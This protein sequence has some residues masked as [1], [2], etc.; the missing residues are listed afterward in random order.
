MPDATSL[1]RIGRIMKAV[2][3][4]ATF[5]CAFT[6]LLLAL[7]GVAQATTAGTVTPN[8]LAF[9][10]V[11]VNA[12]SNQMLTFTNTGDVNETVSSS[13]DVAAFGDAGGCNGAVLTPNATCQ[14]QVSFSPTTTGTSTGTLTV[15]FTSQVDS[16]TA[17]V[18]VPLS[19]TAVYPA[20][21][22]QSTSL[23]PSY[24]YPL[25]RDGYRD[26]ADYAFTLNENATGAIQIYN[27]KGTL[28]RSY[29]FT[30]RDHLA[31]AWGGR[32]SLGEKVK[33]GFYRFRVVAHLPGLSVVSAF[34]RTQVKTGFRLETTRGTKSKLG[35][36]WSSRGSG[37]YSPGGNCNWLA[38]QGGLLTTCLDAHAQINYTFSLP[39]GAKVTSFSHSVSPGIV[40]CRNAKWTTTHTGNVHHATFTHGSAS[41][42]SQC[43]I[44]SLTMNWRHTRKVRI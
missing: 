15:V 18:D 3:L 26:W 2:T 42:F 14:E 20:I 35:T 16:S 36:S 24:F 23:R 41:G 43:E 9:G 29:P 7:P 31:V 6:L 34:L 28:T 33:P 30:D 12:T 17:S 32:N 5:A 39:R 13:I 37:A 40:A 19:A 11:S 1:S 22:V 8:P 10:D 21:H 25:V 27:R 38:D 44:N 4:G